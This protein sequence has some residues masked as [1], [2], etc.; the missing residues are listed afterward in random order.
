MT[1]F[2]VGPGYPLPLGA[3]FTCIGINFALFSRHATA[4]SLVL[5]P[6]GEEEAIAEIPFD[7]KINRTGDIWH[8]LVQG[9]D[10]ALRYGYRVDGPFDPNV[11]GLYFDATRLLLDPYARA[12]SGGSVWGQ[13]HF[14]SG[15]RDCQGILKRRGLVLT[16]EFDWEGDRPLNRPL[17]DTIIYELHVR[18]FTRH[19]SSGVGYPGTYTGIVEK[20]PY[21]KGLGITAV[22]LLPIFEFDEN[23]NINVNPLTNE[24]LKNYWGY[25]PIAFFAPKASFAVNAKNG[26]QVREF[27]EMVKALHREGIEVILDVVFNHT[28]EGQESGPNI[29]LRGLDN[30]IYYLLDPQTRRYLNFTGC[31]NT[32]N[33]NHPVV[34]NLIMDALRYWVIEMHVDGFRFDLASIL[35][36][37][38]QGEVLGNPPIIEQIAEDPILSRTKIIAEAWDAAGLYQVGSF[39]SHFRWAEWN[40]QYRDDVRAF[41]AGRENTIANLA[42]RVAGSSD[43]YQP[44]GRHPYNSINFVTCH[45]GFTLYDLVSYN[46]KHNLANGEEN[47]DGTDTHISW[48]S[49]VEG[50]T[51]VR[52]IKALRGRRIRSFATLLFLS[53]GVPMFL[54]GDEFGRT[55]YGNNNAYCQDNPIGWVDWDLLAKNQGLFRFFSMII[56]LRKRH[57]VFR[58]VDFFPAQGE[59]NWCGPNNGPPDWSSASRCLAWF[60]DGTAN[61]GSMDDDFFVMV[62]SETRPRL[63]RAPVL[64]KEQCWA[65]IIDTGAASP[66]DIV[67]E[68]EGIPIAKNRQIWVGSMAAVVLISR[69]AKI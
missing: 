4:V 22:E 68:E 43:L 31:G 61:K 36:R 23:D 63:F 2:G 53:Q 35:A 14:R 52:R 39:S 13:T 28:G 65:R 45:D 16:D 41:M 9:M 27:K 44:N 47:R 1:I 69:S 26:E 30:S 54:A 57:A 46:Q 24:P 33:G 19:P 50:E 7:P 17:Q 55:Q 5:F 21:L 34:R 48:N 66:Q 25:N 58:R 40:G 12:L 60:L 32:V 67:M 56:A 15:A 29:S 11:W 20:I 51:R 38:Q 59:I 10:P 64:P 3:N 8:I 49:G 6:K 42:T 37:G 18:G 62:N